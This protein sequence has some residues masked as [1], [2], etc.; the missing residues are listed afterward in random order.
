MVNVL[1]LRT[2][3]GAGEVFLL[4]TGLTVIYGEPQANESTE[5]LVPVPVLEMP[6]GLNCLFSAQLSEMNEF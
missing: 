5:P 2:A 3:L 4:H 1:M 6:S